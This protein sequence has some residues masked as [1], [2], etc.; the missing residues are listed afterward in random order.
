MKLK[1][2]KYWIIGASEGLG[3]ELSIQLSN[4][5][6]NLIISAR[7]ETRLTELSSLTKAK[8][9]ALDVLDIDAIKQASKSVGIID[10]IIYV[11]GDYTPLNSTTWNVEEV[12]KMIAVN[13]T[14]AAKV[15]GFI[16]PK[17]LKQ[18]NGHIVMIGSLSGF[19][20]LPNAIG[21][22]A[23]KAA[24]MHL[25]ENIKADLYKTP[26]KIQLINPGFIKTRLTEKNNF[27]MPF[28]MSVEDAAKR[29]IIAMNS[30]RFQTNFPLIFSL[31]FRAS[32]LLPAFIY[33]WLFSSNM[34]K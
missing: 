3:R 2:K 12:D 22:G 4:L 23:S 11:A 5:G 21:Y 1:G 7:N 18:N 20:G 31:L 9:L 13:F 17:F 27:K 14:G 8:V 24:M 15:L 16:V 10:G 32:N 29:V 26:I 19:R 33:F 30:N 34:K 28:I 25:A 6:V